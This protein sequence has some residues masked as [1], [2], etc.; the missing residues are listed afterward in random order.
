MDS[1]YRVF[2][3]AVSSSLTSHEDEKNIHPLS[4]SEKR[5]LERYTNQDDVQDHKRLS[6]VHSVRDSGHGQHLVE[7]RMEVDGMPATEP[8][9][10]SDLQERF[11][12]CDSIGM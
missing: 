1:T 7:S 2:L 6:P 12:S 5:I 3:C 11:R 8:T 9:P 10:S 4:E